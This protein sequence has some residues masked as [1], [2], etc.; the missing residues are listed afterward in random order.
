MLAWRTEYPLLELIDNMVI[1]QNLGESY[2][3]FGARVRH[4]DY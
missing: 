3:T 2:Y 1:Q 4:A